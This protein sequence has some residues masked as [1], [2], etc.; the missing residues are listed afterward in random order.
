MTQYLISFG[1]GAMDHIP[2][3]EMPDVEKETRAVVREAVAAG[4]WVFGGGLLDQTSSVVDT[5]GT[6]T[7]R[8]G[9]GGGM[10]I[11]NVPTRDEALR[12]ATKVAAGCR[13]AQEVREF[14]FDVEQDELL[15]R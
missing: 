8:P 2:E 1:P 15:R 4:V 9:P 3:A 14:M 10:C 12:W 5:D 11:V 6:I 7:E 13:C